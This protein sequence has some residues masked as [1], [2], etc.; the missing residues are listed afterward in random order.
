MT[1][2]QL[3]ALSD[4]MLADIGLVRGD[5]RDFVKRQEN[6]QVTEAGLPTLEQTNYWDSVVRAI[7][8]WDLSRQAAS[9][10]ARFNADTLHDLGYVKGDVDWVPEVM[11]QRKLDNQQAA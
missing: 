10:M 6:G 9:Q 2:R 5:V 4:R 11:A 8:Q 1:I 3:E 7:R